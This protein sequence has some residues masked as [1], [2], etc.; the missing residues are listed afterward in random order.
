LKP[1]TLY[2]DPESHAYLDRDVRDPHQRA[3]VEAILAEVHLQPGDRIMELGAGAGRYTHLLTELGFDVVATEPDPALRQVLESNLGQSCEVAD[4]SAGEDI[5]D[6]I[7]GLV[8]FHVLHH[9]DGSTI[10]LLD[11]AIARR[12]TRTGFKGAAFLEPNPLNPLYLPQI[13]CTPG[14]KLREERRLWSPRFYWSRSSQLGVP[15]HIGIVPPSISRATGLAPASACRV[16][17]RWCP[18]SSY[19]VV[20]TRETAG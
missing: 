12:R 10:E 20:A 16:P 13:L 11:R 2:S 6:D 9:L 5:P 4:A 7:A 18:W 3:I 19:R 17:G 1:S 15:C 14:M 8:G